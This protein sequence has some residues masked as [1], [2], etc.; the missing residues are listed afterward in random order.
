MDRDDGLAIPEVAVHQPLHDF[1]ALRIEP[2]RGAGLRHTAR[3]LAAAQVVVGR[4]GNLDRS[5]EPGL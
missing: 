5:G 1:V 3:Q 4:Y 2:H